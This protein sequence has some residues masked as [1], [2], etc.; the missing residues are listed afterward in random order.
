M[1]VLRVVHWYQQASVVTGT[2]TI[3]TVKKVPLQPGLCT[4]RCPELRSVSPT[5]LQ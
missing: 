5:S 3:R 2:V 4:D 1:H